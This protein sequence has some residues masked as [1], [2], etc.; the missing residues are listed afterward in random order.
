LF[1]DLSIQAV[2]VRALMMSLV[3]M[4]AAIVAGVFWPDALFEQEVIAAGLAMIPALLLAHHRGWSNVSVLLGFGLVALCGVNLSSA[5]LGVSIHGPFLVL[6]LIAPYI[7]IALGAGWFGEVRRYQ[8]ELRVAQLQLIQSEKLDSIGRMAAGVAHEV[9][10]P[11]MVI[12]TGVKILSKRLAESDEQTRMLLQ[13]MTHAVE[14]ADKIIR[15]MLSASGDTSVD[16]MPSDLN[17]TV[18]KSL[19]F[20]KH[21]LERGHVRLVTDLDAA[22]L[23][24]R[25]DEFKIQ[26]VL[27]NL[28]TNALHAMEYEGVLTLTT[29]METVS[30]GPYVGHRQTDRFKPGERIAVVRI[31]DTGPGIPHDHLGKIFDP[32]FTTKPTGR[33]TG[34]GLAVSRQIVDLHGGTIEI[35]NQPAGGALVIM[36]FKLAT[37]E[38]QE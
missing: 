6:F 23:P 35:G 31:G 22:L 33:G 27:I 14:R 1:V 2:P 8:T 32:F 4:G 37:T 29:S 30:R 7:A 34:L 10:N 36:R 21:E 20:I 25:L 17:A 38:P 15:G 28:I 5:Y 26:Q 13:D 12:L 9:K 24:V 19:R 18:Q 3:A 16:V 11:L